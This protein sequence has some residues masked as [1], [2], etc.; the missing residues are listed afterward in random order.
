MDIY[1]TKHSLERY[2]ERLD[3]IDLNALRKTSLENNR[4]KNDSLEREIKRAGVF[5]DMGNRG[6]ICIVN[7]LKAYVVDLTHDGLVI[8]TTLT[9]HRYLLHQT[10]IAERVNIKDVGKQSP[11]AKTLDVIATSD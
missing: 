8:L 9:C 6:I 2:V 4:I 10:K 5:Y 7:N 11:N 1:F 3:E